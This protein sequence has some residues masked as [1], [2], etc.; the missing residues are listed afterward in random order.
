M[1]RALPRLTSEESRAI[2]FSGVKVMGSIH[3]NLI[4]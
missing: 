2:V 4:D 3:F 1:K